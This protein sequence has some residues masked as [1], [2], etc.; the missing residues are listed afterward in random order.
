[1]SLG[2]QMFIKDTIL[3]GMFPC[4]SDIVKLLRNKKQD[5]SYHEFYEY[6]MLL[7]NSNTGGSLNSQLF[8]PT[9]S[10][11]KP[12][13]IDI[14]IFRGTYGTVSDGFDIDM[15]ANIETSNSRKAFLTDYA[16]WLHSMRMNVASIFKNVAIHGRFGV[17]HKVTPEDVTAVNATFSG[18]TPTVGTVFSLNVPSNVYTAGFANG[19]LVIKTQGSGGL[20]PWGTANC[21]EV[22]KIVDNQ[23][24][25]LSL[26]AVTGSTPTSWAA[27]QYIELTDNRVPAPGGVVGFAEDG[28]TWAGTG[29]YTS[30]TTARTGFMEGLADLFPWYADATYNRLGLDLPFRGQPNRQTYTTQ[31]A[32]GWY[33][34]KDGESI[35]DAIMNG[36]RLATLAVPY[37]DL[38]VW[39][40]QDTR[41]GIAAQEQD[42]VTIFKEIAL[43]Q[44]IVFQ[45][46]I[47]AT[48]Y[49]VGSKVIPDTITDDNMPTD[50]IIIGPKM[51][52]SYCT[53]DNAFMKIDEF[54]QTTFS[55]EAPPT[56]E[57]IS[58]PQE[59]MTSLNIGKRFVVGTPSMSDGRVTE[60]LFVHPAD[61]VPVAYHEMGSLFTE[62][63]Y[64]YVVVKLRNQIIDP[65]DCANW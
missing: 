48:S 3:N 65:S 10:L 8:H 32:G 43:S 64:A 56:P 38:G 52:L 35:I 21:A 40:N 61:R 25:W 55:K 6:R 34:Q 14:G 37:E 5:W 58:V 9:G 23:P 47:T 42:H 11:K 19:R 1:M 50:T 4:Q 16:R 12:G 7:A 51:D 54:V 31:M 39:M 29:T 44:P 46:G 17:I 59:L 24:H 57:Q 36:V 27:G 49:T 60:G 26:Q 28:V 18:A 63:P 62:N 2:K 15:I 33:M 53:L 45:R 20:V 41:L 22:Y 13:E 30:G